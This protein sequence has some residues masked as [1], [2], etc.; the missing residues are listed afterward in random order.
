[1]KKLTQR[2]YINSLVF[3]FVAVYFVSYITRINY[4]A[5]L[6]EIIAEKGI[7]KTSASWVVTGSSITY[8]IGQ[9]IS[10]YLGDKVKPQL[11]II[12]GLVTTAVMNLLFP[13]CS[14]G[15]MIAVWCVNGLAQAMMWPPIVKLMTSYLTTEDYKKGS[16]KVSWGSSIG[17]IAVYLLAPVVIG[18]SSW[19]SVFYICG[20]TAAVMVLV[21]KILFD[22]ITSYAE[23]VEI[24]YEKANEVQGKMSVGGIVIFIFAMAGLGIILQGVLRDGITTWMPTYISDVYH[25]GSKVSILTGVVL[26]IF[27]IISFQVSSMVYRTWLRNEFVCAGVIFFVGFISALILAISKSSNAVVSV[28][29][30]ALITGCMHGVNVMLICMLPPY[31]EKYGKVSLVSGAL[32]ACTYIGAAVSTYGMAVISDKFGWEATIVSWTVTAFLGTVVCLATAK[33]WKKFKKETIKELSQ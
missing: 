30:S 2:K 21:F 9:L 12:C 5:V 20:L 24:E 27:S 3:L 29:L 14:Y 6:V 4:G 23:Y 7:T 18:V 16:I 22:K 32:N 31:F 13:F 33:T 26:P 8:G 11:L 1:M 15:V 10:G 25:L 19:K 17:T 28:V